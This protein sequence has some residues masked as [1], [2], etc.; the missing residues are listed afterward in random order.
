M[1]YKPGRPPATIEPRK[2]PTRTRNVSLP[3]SLWKLVEYVQRVRGDP[4][5]S[6]TVRTLLI[7][8]L[9]Q[10]DLLPEETK[11]AHGFKQ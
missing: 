6:A 3:G 1:A 9:C 7:Q 10:L 11:R 2:D 8:S 5:L 4:T